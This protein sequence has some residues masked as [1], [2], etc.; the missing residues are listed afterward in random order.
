MYSVQSLYIPDSRVCLSLNLSLFLVLVLA[1]EVFSSK[2]SGISKFQFDLNDT[3]IFCFGFCL[4]VY[5]NNR[6]LLSKAL[7]CDRK[8]EVHNKY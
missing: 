6:V 8:F 5:L 3:A 4:S 2:K 7:S 1:K